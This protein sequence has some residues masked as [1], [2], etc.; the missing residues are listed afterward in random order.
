MCIVDAKKKAPKQAGEDKT[1]RKATQPSA[2]DLDIGEEEDNAAAKMEVE[3]KQRREPQP[4]DILV[5]T[6]VNC[7]SS[8]LC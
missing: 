3:N 5:E 1:E 6:K 4:E 7:I 8:R 2:E